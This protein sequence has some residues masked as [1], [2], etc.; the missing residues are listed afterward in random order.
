MN[1]ISKKDYNE[2]ITLKT[3]KVYYELWLKKGETFFLQRNDKKKVIIVMNGEKET[4]YPIE[5]PNT[6]RYRI[7][8]RNVFLKMVYSGEK[9]SEYYI[10][11]D[12]D[13]KYTKEVEFEEWLS[14]K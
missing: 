14:Q 7:N 3:K 2:Q 11:Q 9:E 8:K 1:E 6:L 4:K 13:V 12:K 5:V 10:V